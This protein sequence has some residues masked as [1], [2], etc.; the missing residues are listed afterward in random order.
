MSS[1][2][3]PYSGVGVAPNPNAP[4][5]PPAVPNAN[6][7]SGGQNPSPGAM[8]F[9]NPVQ[10]SG[11]TG[12]SS[13]EDPY[14]IHNVGVDMGTVAS[15]T[16]KDGKPLYDLGRDSLLNTSG[17]GQGVGAWVDG[18]PPPIFAG[19]SKYENPGAA[20]GN[21]Y[22]AS[23]GQ[24]SAWAAQQG[25]VSAQNLAAQTAQTN[26]TDPGSSNYPAYPNSFGLGNSGG[27]GGA[28]PSQGVQTPSSYSQN[29]VTV[30]VPDT[31]SRGF[32]PWSMV[33]E[34]NSRDTGKGVMSQGPN[35]GGGM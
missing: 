25:G 22:S 16:D 21:P 27:L 31:S 17:F 35:A 30:N 6:L 11:W 24:D 34:S 2:Y 12:V 29:G 8:Q 10:Q 1:G 13:N 4:K 15:G 28:S 19:T 14:G 32:S 20:E 3:T 18:K 23:N 5:L 26:P 9:G 33:G 7:G